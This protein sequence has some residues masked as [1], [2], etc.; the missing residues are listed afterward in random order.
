MLVGLIFGRFFAEQAA[1]RFTKREFGSCADGFS[2]GKS[3]PAQ[4]IDLRAEFTERV[5]AAGEFFGGVGLGL[6]A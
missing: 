3:I 2:I 5:D 4:I 1:D 6:T